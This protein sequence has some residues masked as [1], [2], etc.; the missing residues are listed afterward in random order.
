ME[1]RHYTKEVV[2]IQIVA[3]GTKLT[4]HMIDHKQETVTKIPRSMIYIVVLEW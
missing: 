2:D 1:S 4:Q 3:M